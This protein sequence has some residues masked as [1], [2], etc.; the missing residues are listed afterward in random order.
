MENL[1]KIDIGSALFQTTGCMT[2]HGIIELINEYADNGINGKGSTSYQ[3][4]KA[5]CE[6]VL[7]VNELYE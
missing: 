7:K 5:I 6:S 2:M 4:I 3:A 1:K